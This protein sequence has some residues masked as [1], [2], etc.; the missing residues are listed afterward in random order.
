[1]TSEL[2]TGKYALD[3]ETAVWRKLPDDTE[4]EMEA[5]DTKEQYVDS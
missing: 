2:D 1:L 5:E 4:F 3:L